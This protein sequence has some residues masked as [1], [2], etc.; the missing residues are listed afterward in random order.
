MY[1][2]FV[3]SQRI[4]QGVLRLKRQKSN[5]LIV[6]HLKLTGGE[7]ETRR[8]DESSPFAFLDPDRFTQGAIR[9]NG[10]ELPGEKPCRTAEQIRP[11]DVKDSRPPPP[12]SR[13]TNADDP[14]EFRSLE[15]AVAGSIFDGDIL[16]NIVSRRSRMRQYANATWFVYEILD[17]VVD[18]LGP[19]SEVYRFKLEA[20]HFMLSKVGPQFKKEDREE[21]I[22][23]KQQIER[24]LRV[25]RPLVSVLKHLRENSA[26]AMKKA[27]D[28]Q[29]SESNGNGTQDRDAND[30]PEQLPFYFDDVSE[31][32][33]VAI[34]DLE[35]VRRID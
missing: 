10:W 8:Y 29:M 9:G 5:L 20:L 12:L 11:T 27:A 30:V 25:V 13:Q 14:R 1:M 35:L 4:W 34:S 23:T 2:G 18:L 31:H 6:M 33:T 26:R 15:Q 28:E 17:Q 21:V 24:V 22:R 32:L 7:D 16:R 19:I 3:V